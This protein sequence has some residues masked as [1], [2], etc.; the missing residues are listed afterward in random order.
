MQI[1]VECDDDSDSESLLSTDYLEEQFFGGRLTF[2]LWGMLVIEQIEDA[3]FQKEEEEERKENDGVLD[4]VAQPFDEHGGND[5]H[6]I[7]GDIGKEH[8][9]FIW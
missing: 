7:C 6:V 3:F 1:L 8:I 9:G 4:G 2:W 5:G